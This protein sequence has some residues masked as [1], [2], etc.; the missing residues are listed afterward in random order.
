MEVIIM[1]VIKYRYNGGHDIKGFHSFNEAIDWLI[2]EFK[3]NNDIIITEFEE[4]NDCYGVIRYDIEKF[5]N[6]TFMIMWQL[7]ETQLNIMV[8][9]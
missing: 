7:K 5:D 4:T 9:A 1:F 3:S 2:R 6:E 8:T